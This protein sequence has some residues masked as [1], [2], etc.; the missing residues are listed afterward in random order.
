MSEEVLGNLHIKLSELISAKSRRDQKK[1]SIMQLS[2][3]LDMPHSILVKLCHHDPEKRVVNPRIK[4]LQRIIDYFQK[5]GFNVTIAD[6]IANDNEM[7]FIN[8]SIHHDP[9]SIPLY[10]SDNLVSI[11]SCEGMIDVTIKKEHNKLIAIRAKEYVQPIFLPGSL[12]IV[13]TQAI[14][15][16]DHMLAV[17]DLE[18]NKVIFRKLHQQGRSRIIYSLSTEDKSIDLNRSKSV[19]VIGVVIQINMKV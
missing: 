5:D 14:P 8:S 11:D 1:F 2:K 17:N 16:D 6:L 3:A 18:N 7:S 15:V 9:I 4:T 19:K 13:D 10:K 12:F